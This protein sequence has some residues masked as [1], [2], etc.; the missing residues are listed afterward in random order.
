MWPV[1]FVVREVFADGRYAEL[2]RG[3]IIINPSEHQFDIEN[4]RN[5][6]MLSTITQTYAMH[7]TYKSM[8]ENI[9]DVFPNSYVSKKN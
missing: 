1:E 5:S 6:D 3:R 8:R 2:L 9:E 7:E 4:S